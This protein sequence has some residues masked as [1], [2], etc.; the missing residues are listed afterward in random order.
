MQFTIFVDRKINGF[1]MLYTGLSDS[2][3]SAWVCVDIII[4]ERL[5]VVYRFVL[6][7]IFLGGSML[8]IGLCE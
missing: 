2:L 7:E 8:Y 5:S 6:I 3:C 1:F 4:C